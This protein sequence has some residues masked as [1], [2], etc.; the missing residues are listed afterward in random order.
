MARRKTIE[1][2]VETLTIDQV[3]DWILAPP[4]GFTPHEPDKSRS[5]HH[6]WRARKHAWLAEH[7]GDFGTLKLFAERQRRAA[8]QSAREGA[9]R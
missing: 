2:L 5:R 4:G 6:D 7:D 8:E 1:E 9:V 3:P